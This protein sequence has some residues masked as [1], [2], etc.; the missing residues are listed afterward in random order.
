MR[1]HLNTVWW[2]SQAG[3]YHHYIQQDG[4]WL[5]DKQMMSFLLRWDVGPAE[6]AAPVEEGSLTRCWPADHAYA[7]PFSACAEG[8]GDASA[9]VPTDSPAPL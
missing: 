2:D 8:D 6:R 4:T 1:T 7:V 9:F 5:D 3:L